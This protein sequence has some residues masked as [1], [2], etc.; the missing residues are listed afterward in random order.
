MADNI[1]G[2]NFHSD[3]APETVVMCAVYCTHTPSAELLENVVMAHRSADELVDIGRAFRRNSG[4]PSGRSDGFG[5]DR[6]SGQI[7]P[8]LSSDSLVQEGLHFIEQTL[9]F[10]TG[11]SEKRYPLMTRQC[12]R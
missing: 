7:Q 3:V 2:Q 1:D 6:Q 5:E 4:P 10:S 9:V 12:G 11:S 8:T